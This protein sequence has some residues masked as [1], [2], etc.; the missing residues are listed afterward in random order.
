MSKEIRT[1]V[2]NTIPMFTVDEYLTSKDIDSFWSYLSTQ[3]RG[4]VIEEVKVH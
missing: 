2:E 1:A 4:R 3:N